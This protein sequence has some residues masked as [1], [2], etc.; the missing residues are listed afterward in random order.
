MGKLL[1]I[2]NIYTRAFAGTKPGLVVYILKAY[3][4]F[5]AFLIFMALYAF[6]EG[7]LTGFHF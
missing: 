6:V 2:K 7:V 3:A 5:A 1:Q 4:I